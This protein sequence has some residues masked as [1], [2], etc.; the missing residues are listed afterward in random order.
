LWHGSIGANYGILKAVAGAGAVA[1]IVVG[2]EPC[3]QIGVGNGSNTMTAAGTGPGAYA[4]HGIEKNMKRRSIYEIGVRIDSSIRT[5]HSD[6]PEVG[7]GRRVK[8]RGGR[9]V[10]TG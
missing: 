2:G 8:L 4:G 1:G 6:S 9:R 5:F 3:D 7:A 10:V